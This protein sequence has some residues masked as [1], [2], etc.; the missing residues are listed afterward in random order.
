MRMRRTVSIN[1]KPPR[2]DPEARKPENG[3]TEEDLSSL[4]SDVKNPKQVKLLTAYVGSKSLLKAQSLAGVH[5]HS[6]YW[7][8]ENDPKYPTY[9]RRARTIIADQVE[10][11]AYH[12]AFEGT[13]WPIYYHG[14]IIGYYKIYSDKLAIFM[15]KAMKP[16]IYGNK[17]GIEPSGK[18]TPDFEVIIKHEGEDKPRE[19][20]LSRYPRY[21]GS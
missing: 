3:E 4:F 7:W 8:M 2:P 19:D 13:D 21:E 20:D 14:R 5:R 11:E 16:E 9:F 15:L 18:A 10:E 1:K 6:H 12:R 17:S